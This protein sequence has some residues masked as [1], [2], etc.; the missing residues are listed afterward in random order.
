AAVPVAAAV[1][2][3]A[4][5]VVPAAAA[6]K[7]RQNCRTPSYMSRR[8]VMRT[9]ISVPYAMIAAVRWTNVRARSDL[10]R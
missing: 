9:N 3:A 8:L 1:V 6:N 2:P 7:H 4:A 5:A 10:T